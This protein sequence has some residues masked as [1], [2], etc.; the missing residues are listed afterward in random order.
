MASTIPGADEFT[1]RPV[2]REE[3]LRQ[4]PPTLPLHRID[5]RQA[6]EVNAL[7]YEVV[8]HRLWAVT[9][10][11]GETLRRMSGSH[12]VTESND[13]NFSICDELGEQVQVGAY[14]VSLIGSMDLAI[15]WTL[16]NRSEN[17]GIEEG[18]MFLCNDPWIG[19]GLHQND[20]AVLAPIFHEGRLFGW[21]TAIAHQ[22]DLGGPRPG[23]FS[24]SARDVF[25]EAVPT[26]P[27]K[28]V[29]G[30]V[31]QRD[32]ADAWV[33][34]SRLPHMVGLDLRAKIAANRNA[35]EQILRLID[36][37]GADTVKAVMRRMMDDAESRLRDKLRTLP[38]GTWSAV[39]Y[40]EQS[41]TGDRDLHA[42]HVAMTK[43]DDRLVFD[44]RGTA[45]QTG[46]INCPY[47]GLR[48]GIVF[49]MLPLLA[50]DIPWAAG[51]L[52][53]CFEIVTDEDTLTNASFPAAVGKGPFGPAWGSGNLVAEVIARMLDAE[54]DHREDVQSIC[55]GTTDLCVVSGVD[56]RGGG[57]KGFVSPVFDVM[58]GGYGAQVHHDGVDTGGRLIIPSAKAPDVEMTEYLYPLLALWRREET[59][60]G[61]PG[62]RRGGMSGSVCYVQHPD[63]SGDMSL[64]VSG[65]G[66]VANQNVGLAGGHPGNSQLDL[67]VR[68][69][70]VPQLAG[71]RSMPGGLDDLGGTV[72][73]LPCEGESTL[74]AGDALY[75]HWQ[76]GGGYGDPL[77]RPAEDVREDVLQVRVSPD[78]ARNVYGLVL[79]AD[80][81]VDATATEE[82]RAVLRH[83]RA[84][85]AGLTGA[86]LAPIGTPRPD[87]VRRLDD[88]LAVEVESRTVI[89]VHCGTGI[90][91]LGKSAFV[92]GLA[93]REVAPTEAGP[94]IW[95]D[96]SVY[97]DADVVFRQLCCPGCLTAVH[98]RVVPVGHPLPHDDYRSWA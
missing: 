42:L 43:Q 50:G 32:V 13:F 91:P 23:S 76:A 56:V 53:R 27:M 77:L 17:P 19:G 31:L 54:P 9:Q 67:V 86:A 58:A 89:C 98:S 71:A 74:G 6:E 15:V 3:L 14:N 41:G 1:S 96:P 30:G 92:E 35:A 22:V 97:V 40:Q 2:P 60:S 29:R 44:F 95:H 21:T 37:Y 65:T 24:P 28:V 68:G 47:P 83:R 73:V 93:R 26:P 46:V 61:G 49:T 34:R 7:T 94:H 8:R 66:K 45:G 82:A 81:E 38:D 5:E 85:D 75:L 87:G 4:I 84:T 16:R 10:E 57:H 90:G 39:G 51:G 64:V 25:G 11:M 69:I 20:A 72:E 70:D 78:A 33:R 18:D 79:R 80:G 55:N 12:V 88:N 59:D 63:Q 48:A 62:R 52:M 36:K